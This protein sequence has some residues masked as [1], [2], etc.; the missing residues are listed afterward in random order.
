MRKRWIVA[1]PVLLLLLLPTLLVAAGPTT[2]TYLVDRYANNAGPGTIR[3]QLLRLINV[4]TGG[5]PLTSPVGDVCANIYVFDA[6]QEMISCCSCRLT[7]NE[8]VTASVGNQLTNNPLTSIIPSAGVIKI[9]P[10]AAGTAVCNPAAPSAP[11][12]ASL[13]MGFATHL[14]TSTAA[15]FITETNV[16]IARLASGEA[17]F[18]P[19][20]CLFVTHLGGAY[21]RGTCSCTQ[22]SELATYSIS[23]TISGAGGSGATV[24]LTEAST[25][26]V[27]ADAAGTATVTAD[28]SGN[29]TFVGMSNG[30]YTITPSRSGFSFSPANQPVT[31]NSANVTGV[32]FSTVTYSISGTISGTGGNGATLN[33]TGTSSATVT[34]DVSGNYAFT[35]LQNGSYT[36]TPSNSGFGFSPTNRSVTLSSANVTGVNFSAALDYSV[37][38]S[39]A[40]QSALPNTTVSYMVNTQSINNFVAKLQMSCSGLPSPA[41][42]NVPTTVA[43]G[44]SAQMSAQIN[45]L[46]PGNYNFI[47]TGASGGNTSSA[48]AQLKVVDFGATLSASSETIPAGSSASLTINVT[49]QNGFADPVTLTCTGAP[50]GVS[51]TINPNSIS[52]SGAATMTITVNS[53]PV[54]AGLLTPGGHTQAPALQLLPAFICAGCLALFVIGRTR[55]ARVLAALAVTCTLW[56]AVSCGGGSFSSPASPRSATFTLTVQAAADQVTKTAGTVTVT[57]P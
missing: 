40:S 30:S 53:R 17:A 55:Q 35:G 5:T 32:N 23:G 28:A 50:V 19:N 15:T 1:G 39:P 14:E 9:L 26:T 4:A 33:L 11:S 22:G 51:C 56:L 43:A 41:V 10:T 20:A 8:T 37:A 2:P 7:P 18:L 44:S 13:V 27:T 54:T 45:S 3:D 12:N 6:N 42:C 31:V 34:A 52:G 21:G 46:A 16:P 24:S 38:I 49:G 29:Y 57:V 25:A 36:V 47:V 48:S